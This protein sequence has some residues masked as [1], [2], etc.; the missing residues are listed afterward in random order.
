MCKHFRHDAKTILKLF[1]E[2]GVPRRNSFDAWKI[3][4]LLKA[5]PQITRDDLYREYA[6]DR[7]TTD[8]IGAQHG[9]PARTIRR[10]LK[11]YN[12]FP[13]IKCP[14]TDTSI[15][16]SLEGELAK[17]EIGFYKQHRIPGVAT[18]DEAFPFEKI[19]VFCDGDYWHSLERA[20]KRDAWVN[21]KLEAMGWVVL[22][23][24]E[25]QINTDVETVVDEIMKILL[26]KRKR[27]VQDQE[28]G[29]KSGI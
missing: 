12:I 20:R 13:R 26:E 19:A 9:I 1:N 11:R 6:V 15:E 28:N 16:R 21:A 24:T 2:Y 4:K 8:W 25:H 27:W 3:R 22:R 5:P 7:R 10:Y 17:R 18:A 14:K 29:K 23:F